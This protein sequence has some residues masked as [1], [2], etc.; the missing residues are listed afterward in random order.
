[1]KPKQIGQLI[2]SLIVFSY[3]LL[4]I[5]TGVSATTVYQQMVYTLKTMASWL[6]LIWLAI[7]FKENGLI[8]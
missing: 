2:L 8:K 5:S 1:M 6:C 7:I 3:M 4:N